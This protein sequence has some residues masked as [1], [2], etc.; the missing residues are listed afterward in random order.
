MLKKI[1]VFVWFGGDIYTS[2]V[3]CYATLVELYNASFQKLFL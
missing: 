3:Q 1:K 2:I